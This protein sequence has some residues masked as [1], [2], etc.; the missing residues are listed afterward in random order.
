M[1]AILITRS[2][3][4]GEI[5]RQI[6]NSLLQFN[7]TCDPPRTLVTSIQS[8]RHGKES[9]NAE[10]EEDDEEA[11]MN[12]EDDVPEPSADQDEEDENLHLLAD[13]LE[14]D[15]EPPVTLLYDSICIF[16][17]LFFDRS[18]SQT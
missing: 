1:I 2:S 18:S 15:D 8:P 9:T 16:P 11:D 10:S 14:V 12:D 4:V 13:D 5:S 3:V 6:R 17:S 7:K